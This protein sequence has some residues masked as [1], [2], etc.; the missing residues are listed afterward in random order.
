MALSILIFLAAC[1]QTDLERIDAAAQTVGES[2]AADVWPELPA[3]CRRTS[4]SGIQQGDRLD[5]AVLKAD[6]ALARQNARTIRCADWYD[7]QRADAAAG[8]VE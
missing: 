7:Q 2:R 1:G 6:E 8:S 4:R 3:D 5:V